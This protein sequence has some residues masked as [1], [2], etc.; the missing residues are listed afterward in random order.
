MKLVE[1]I[2]IDELDILENSCFKGDIYSKNQLCDILSNKN[3]YKVIAVE[4]DDK[5][6]IGYVIILDNS[7]SYE[8]M[9]IG[10]LEKY[11]KKGVGKIL[12]DHISS[13]GK[14]I[15]LEVRE[16]NYSAI[17]FYC[18]NGF[19]IIGKRK[20]YYTDT[21]EAAIIMIKKIDN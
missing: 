10:T 13:Y 11:R 18:S 21:N 7:E 17:S 2:S 9:K 12:L 15:Y 14:N 1:S 19:E 3:L 16:T 20:H 4:L 6:K 5:E 8:I